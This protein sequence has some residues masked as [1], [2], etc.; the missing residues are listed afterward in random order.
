[1][2]LSNLIG[3]FYKTP[4]QVAVANFIIDKASN[5]SS[6]VEFGTRGGVLAL[7]CFQ[8]LLKGKQKWEPRY[9]GVD[10]AED[11]SVATLKKLA[12]T[13]GISFQ[14]TCQSSKNYP[15]HETDMFVWDT[16]HCA[17]NLL[18]DL[19]RMGPYVRKYILIKGIISD[20]ERSEAV[21]RKLDIDKVASELE[22]DK[23]GAEMGLKDALQNF[24]KR[25]VNWEIQIVDDYAFMSRK[26]PF[27]TCVFGN[28]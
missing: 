7:A 10:L 21:N 16:F 23:T 2:D 13:V 1:M 6:I 14:F 17:G 27:K 20:G 15:I 26:T 11:E 25:D 3:Q 8:G 12:D 18:M 28:K 5:C 19:L 24:M 9:N 4:E 22:I